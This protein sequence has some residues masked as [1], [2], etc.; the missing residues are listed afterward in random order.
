MIDINVVVKENSNIPIEEYPEVGV[1]Y[2]TRG[3][4]KE[5]MGELSGAID[6]FKEAI[7]NTEYTKNSTVSDDLKR[8][9]DKLKP[10]E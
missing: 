8:V 6:D 4:V 9:K 1:W 3:E 10:Q 5:A 2:H 7:R